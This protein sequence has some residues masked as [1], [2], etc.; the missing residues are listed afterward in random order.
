MKI[1]NKFWII[2]IFISVIIIILNF[3]NLNKKESFS[4]ERDLIK[5]K[6]KAF[7]FLFKDTINYSNS[8]FNISSIFYYNDLEK[9]D[10]IYKGIEYNY[11]NSK[12]SYKAFKLANRPSFY[13]KDNVYFTKNFNAYKNNHIISP[14]DMKVLKIFD[15]NEEY[16]I[17]ISERI[18][19]KNEYLTG[20]Y[21][22]SKIDINDIKL[23]GKLEINKKTKA[24]ENSLIYNGYFSN[25]SKHI[26]YNFDKISRISLINKNDLSLFNVSTIDN[27]SIPEL[28]KRVINKDTLYTYRRGKT[29]N[30]N[31]GSFS[32]DDTLFVCSY[33]T[34]KDSQII[35]DKYLINNNKYF[36]SE[37]FILKGK[38]NR[39]LTSIYFLLNKPIFNFNNGAEI[40][41][42][43]IKSK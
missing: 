12:K 42:L 40:Y 17:S 8:I 41:S 16:I 32:I 36:K 6:N 11:T 37:S 33:R 19:S 28:D 4:L 22:I 10:S 26:N 21:L 9:N 35:L 25:N 2:V 31:L 7:I 29:F 18:V 38:S 20:F 43:N 3:F 14:S 34:I 5:S 27:V 13:D 15:F 1:N 30:S 24:A 39:D 23:I